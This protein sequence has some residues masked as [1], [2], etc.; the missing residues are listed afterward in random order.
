MVI[1]ISVIFAIYW[2]AIQVPYSLFVFANFNAGLVQIGIF[3]V[4]ALFNSSINPFVYA[5]FNQNVL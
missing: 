2:S 4:L 1:I 5:L 3:I